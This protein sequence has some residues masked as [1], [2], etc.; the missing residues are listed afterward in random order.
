[1]STNLVAK[2]WKKYSAGEHDRNKTKTKPTILQ[3][4]DLDMPKKE[5]LL[6]NVEL[7]NVVLWIKALK[8]LDHDISTNL[9]K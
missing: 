2:P 7:N 8:A 1:M 5:D 3:S 9:R 4:A 6:G